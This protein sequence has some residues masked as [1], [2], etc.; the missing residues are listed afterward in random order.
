MR[1]LD[2]FL[3]IE[4]LGGR[5]PSIDPALLDALLTCGRKTS[6]VP[7]RNLCLSLHEG[8]N[9]GNQLLV[10]EGFSS[11]GLVGSEL[12]MSTRTSLLS[13]TDDGTDVGRSCCHTAALQSS[14]SCFSNFMMMVIKCVYRWKCRLIYFNTVSR[15][16]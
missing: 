5:S 9:E 11:I 6:C 10:F 12:G 16:F 13:M 2:E 7:F 15:T 4:D 1:G 8:A 3:S 14:L